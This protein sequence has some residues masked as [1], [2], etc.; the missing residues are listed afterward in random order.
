[1]KVKHII[2]TCG[3]VLGGLLL[4]KGASAV[5]TYKTSS[6]VQFTWD[7]SLSLTLSEDDFVIESVAPGLSADSNTVTATVSTN[8]SLGYTLTASVGNSTDYTSTALKT[9]ESTIPMLTA[10]AA[11]LSEGKWGLGVVSNS[12]T[13]YK[14]LPLY[15]DT[16]KT[17]NKTTN[18]SG[19]AA[20]NYPGGSTTTMK[21]GAYPAGTQLPGTYENVVNFAVVANVGTRTI[22]L[23]AGDGVT[24]VQIG[25]T[26]GTV[27]GSYA[28]GSTVTIAATCDTGYSFNHWYNPTDFGVIASDTTASTNYTVGAGDVTLTAYCEAD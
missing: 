26:A 22:T 1:M 21:V 19:T 4:A 13:S 9:S 7:G 28:E 8:S 24:A 16:A 18:S 11:A 15:S 23:A 3:I 12:T 25:D 2:T 6:N 27:T 5:V 17:I 10:D 20:D 14:S